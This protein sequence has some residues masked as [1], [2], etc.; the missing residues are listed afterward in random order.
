MIGLLL[1]KKKNLAWRV[2]DGDAIVISLDD[3]PDKGGEKIKVFNETATN[4]WEL[5]N[6]KNSISSMVKKITCEYDIESN[7][8]EASVNAFLKSLLQKKLIEFTGK[9]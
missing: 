6:G 4:I 1:G 8:A 7:H 2:I 3:Q 5:I 9:G